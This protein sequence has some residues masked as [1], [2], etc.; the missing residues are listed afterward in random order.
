MNLTENPIFLTQKRLTHRAGVLAAVL[1][2][3]LDRF[4][5]VVRT[6]RLSGRPARFRFSFAAGS[7]QNI[8]RLGYWRGNP[9]AGHGRVQQDFTGAGRRPQSRFVGQQPAHADETGG[10]RHWLLVRLPAARILHGRGARG[11]RTGH[12]R[13]GGIARH[14]VVRHANSDFEHGI[15]LRSARVRWSAWRSNGRKAASSCCCRSFSSRCLSFAFPRFIIINFLL[16]IYGIVNLFQG[17]TGQQRNMTTFSAT[18]ALGRIF[19]RCRF[20]RLF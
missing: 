20:R 1:I 6:H 5:P 17:P 4:E 13:A 15:V 11:H 2:A 3:A 12:R 14:V 18:G 16:P 8:L 19:S 10:N 7:R 9:G